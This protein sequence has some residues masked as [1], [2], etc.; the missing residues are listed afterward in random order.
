[1][2][3]PRVSWTGSRTKRPDSRCPIGYLHDSRRPL[4]EVILELEALA[5]TEASQSDLFADHGLMTECAGYCGV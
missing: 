1:M 4:A 3:G 2:Y 5:E